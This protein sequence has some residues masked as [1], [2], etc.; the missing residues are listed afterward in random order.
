MEVCKLSVG[1]ETAEPHALSPVINQREG[2]WSDSKTSRLHGPGIA[3][4]LE[5]WNA[6]ERSRQP[7]QAIAQRAATLPFVIFLAAC[8]LCLERV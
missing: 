5:V 6:V 7:R 2:S 1:I 4:A 8:I 3:A